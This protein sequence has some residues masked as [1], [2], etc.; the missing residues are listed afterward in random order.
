M[1]GPARPASFMRHLTSAVYLSDPVLLDLGQ[2]ELLS[3]SEIRM[4][5]GW[6]AARSAWF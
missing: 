4:L 1:P 3:A 6:V 2:S 5:H